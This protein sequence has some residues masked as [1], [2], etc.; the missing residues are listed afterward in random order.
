MGFSRESE[1]GPRKNLFRV[2]K[3]EFQGLKRV[4]REAVLGKIGVKEGMVLDN[5]LLLK[6][7]EK[8]YGI[9]YFEHVQAERKK[10]KGK[11]VLRFILREKPVITSVTFEGNDEIDEDDLKSH[12]KTKNF[13]ILDENTLKSDV[14]SIQKHYEEKGFSCFC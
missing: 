13:D 2:D 1:I 8:I 10:V 6:D 4:E 5:Y 3:I 9:K 14:L 12:I 7:I 11:N